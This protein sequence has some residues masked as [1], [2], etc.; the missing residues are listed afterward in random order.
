MPK[1]ILEAGRKAQEHQLVK[2]RELYKQE[3]YQAALF[4]YEQASLPIQFRR[5]SID[6]FKAIKTCPGP[7]DPKALDGRA[8]AYLKLR[9]YDAALKDARQLIAMA[10]TDSKVNRSLLRN[11]SGMVT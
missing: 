5:T 3:K 4:T 10:K 1:L 7:P 6:V 8:A 11:F 2:A 9:N